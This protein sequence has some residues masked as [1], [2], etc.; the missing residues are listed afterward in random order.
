FFSAGYTQGIQQAHG[1]YILVMN[2]DMLVEGNTLVQ[3]V[4][5]MDNDP[6]IG[7]ATTTMHFSDGKL[8]RN[9]SRFVT[10]GYLLLEYTFIGKLFAT[11][12]K[13]AHD[14]L[15]YADWDRTTSRE[16]DILPGSCIIAS[17]EIWKAIGGFDSRM[18]MYFSDDYF[19]RA[20]QARSKQTWYL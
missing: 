5:Q 9:C 20:V 10:Y 16:V 19:S 8:Q 17:A 18:L 12:Y 3:L 11:Q 7:A 6:A 15:W 14:W 1:R 2:S 4:E 13:V